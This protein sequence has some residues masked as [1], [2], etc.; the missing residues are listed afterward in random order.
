MY[1]K[2]GIKRYNITQKAFFTI[3]FIYYDGEV[4]MVTLKKYFYNKN[5]KLNLLSNRI[6]SNNKRKS[7]I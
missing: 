6:G 4:F 7:L 5:A 1:L 3:A 2:T